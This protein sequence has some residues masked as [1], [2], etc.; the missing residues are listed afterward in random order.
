MISSLGNLSLNLSLIFAF[1][2]FLNSYHKKFYSKTQINKISVYGLLLFSFI[3]FFS[4][5]YSY[6]ISDFSLLNVYQN[7][8]TSKPLFYKISAV[9]GNHEGS[10]L[11]WILVL[12]IFN[13]FLFKLN[14]QKNSILILK[15]DE[16]HSI[17]SNNPKLSHN[18]AI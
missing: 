1:L 4:L 15:S 8:H 16:K 11:L 17:I 2:Q 13:Y 18:F 9:W 10:M 6:I 3:S 7:S 12:T 14:N 5:I